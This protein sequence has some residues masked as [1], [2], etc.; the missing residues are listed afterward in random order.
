MQ[1]YH[2][3]LYPALANNYLKLNQL[4]SALLY[5]Y[6]GLEYAKK[7]QARAYISSASTLISTIYQQMNE[8]SLAIKYAKEG[9]TI[10]ETIQ[11]WDHAYNASEQ[12]STLYS[13]QGNYYEAFQY[14]TK[15]TQYKDSVIDEKKIREI[16]QIKYR[17]QISEAETRNKLLIAQQEKQEANLAVQEG[18]I[19]RQRIAGIGVLVIISLLC[20]FSLIFYRSYRKQQKINQ[21]LEQLNQVK[22][23]IFSVISHDLRGPVD[24]LYQILTIHKSRGQFR[25]SLGREYEY[26]YDKVG[27]TTTLL[28]NLLKW[29]KQQL[30]G[31]DIEHQHIQLHSEI[32]NIIDLFDVQINTKNLSIIVEVSPS[33]VVYNN[34]HGFR[35]VLQNLLS[36]AIKFSEPYGSIDITARDHSDHIQLSVSDSGIGIPLERH[37][38][39]FQLNTYSQP[40]TLL[41]SGVGLGLIL[42]KE[43]IEQ[44]GGEI[45]FDSDAGKGSTFH[46]TV[47]G[48]DT[49]I[50]HNHQFVK[51][52]N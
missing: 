22:N 47:P 14:M 21:Q 19:L 8:I 38:Q 32:L 7:D 33:L 17:Y 3:N 25:E 2:L 52:M 39:I 24:T 28:Q 45:W 26:L 50:S 23:K 6:K 40:G 10:A 16:E 27:Q 34:I 44:M 48:H 15:Y 1:L 20:M 36:N 46:F 18:I 4:G 49:S 42:C 43:Y 35:H 51:E 11:R 31:D 41:E 29:A 9:L 12:L 30:N 37:A 13:D 5:A